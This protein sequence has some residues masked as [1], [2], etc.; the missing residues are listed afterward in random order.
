M[1]PV[2]HYQPE[3]PLTLTSYDFCQQIND[4]RA[5]ADE[6]EIEHNKLLKKI[7]DEC[8]EISLE[9][10][11]SERGK[12]ITGCRLNQEQMLL[13]GMR[14]S[15]VV[16]RKVRSWIKAISQQGT[17]TAS[18]AEAIREK[19]E[20]LE[21]EVI[22]L[23]Q[24]R[25]YLPHGNSKPVGYRCI[26]GFQSSGLSADFLRAVAYRCCVETK[27]RPIITDNGFEVDATFYHVRQMKAA[28]ELVREQSVLS[29]TGKSWRHP[30][31]GIFR[32]R[33]PDWGINDGKFELAESNNNS[34]SVFDV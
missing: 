3:Q 28:I 22:L 31:L 8:P 18:E 23:K 5:E 4:F 33:R 9:N 6:P 15:K 30:A 21:R 1:M 13:V 32:P 17:I 34:G 26:S 29:E 19:Q 2:T 16:R 20:Q 7:T 27:I 11:S 24:Q 12:S 10:L 25:Q 14:E